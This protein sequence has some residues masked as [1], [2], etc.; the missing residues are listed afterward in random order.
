MQ[1]YVSFDRIAWLRVGTR[2]DFP[3]V[4]VMDLRY[5]VRTDI[6]IV[7]TLGRG[8]WGMQGVRAYVRMYVR[9]DL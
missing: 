6:L 1:V 4:L 9:V 8:V 5:D 3:L 2:A 7:P